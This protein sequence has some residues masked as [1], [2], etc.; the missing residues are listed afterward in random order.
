M[1][2]RCFTYCS[3][4]IRGRLERTEP[5]CRSICLRRVFAHEVQKILATHDGQQQTVQ[6]K[7]PL[8]PEGQRTPSLTELLT[9]QPA[10][11]EDK[12]Q[13]AE[14]RHWDEGY[15]FWASKSRWAAQERMDLMMCDLEHQ[16]EWQRYKDEMNEQWAQNVGQVAHH[17]AERDATDAHG[18]E[19]DHG[20]HDPLQK[21]FPD[22][23]DESIL[24]Q[25][26]IPPPLNP[27]GDQ[28]TNLLAPS[29]KMLGLV[30]ATVHSGEQWGFAKRIWEKAWTPEPFVLA[31]NV[32]SKMWEKWKNEPPNDSSDT[33][34]V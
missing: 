18:S 32:C 20:G 23:L 22:L 24:L 7:Y 33:P 31:R 30:Y 11:E 16:T 8:P 10:D 13:P 26:P 9:G 2:E 25:I 3:Q 21:P 6:T 14:A 15:Y 28:I 5:Y 34:K 27:F 12:S 4:T 19:A 29:H 1:D 17:P